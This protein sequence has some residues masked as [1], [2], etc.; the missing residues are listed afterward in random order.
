MTVKL[1]PVVEIRFDSSE[2]PSV[3]HDTL[4]PYTSGLDF[5]RISELTQSNLVQIIAKH[6]ERSRHAEYSR[7][8]ASALFG[9]YV[10]KVKE[11]DVYFPQCCGDLSDIRYWEQLVIAKS[12]IPGNGHPGPRVMI[13]K[14]RIRL[15]FTVD[16]LD[17]KFNP[18][19]PYK[20][21]DINKKELEIALVDARFEL[22]TFANK[23]NKINE[24]LMFGLQGIDK[25]LTGGDN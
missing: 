24:D 7:Q 14:H 19:P 25:L 6:T 16:G 3:D 23:L 10:L 2:A 20:F 4:V 5:Y 13:N 22:A 21:V 11:E 9:G 15:D 18:E 12:P 17:E 8:E 1:I